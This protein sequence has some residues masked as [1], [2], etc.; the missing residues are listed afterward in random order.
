M[1]TENQKK[2]KKKLKAK[3][4]NKRKNKKRKKYRC[5]IKS[6]TANLF[7]LFVS[8]K[9]LSPHISGYF[10]KRRFFLSVFRQ[11][12]YASTLRNAIKKLTGHELY[13]DCWR[14]S[15][16]TISPR[17]QKSPRQ[18]VVL[19]ICVFS[20]TVY[21]RYVHVDARPNGRKEI[22]VFEENRI[23]ETRLILVRTILSRCKTLPIVSQGVVLD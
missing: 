6:N 1:S 18:R 21:S 7:L 2:K 12:Q 3:T 8:T 5:R 11:K 17:F 14:S 9:A 4:K 20:V 19:K 15:T 13:D 22:S 16:K 23:C 10:S